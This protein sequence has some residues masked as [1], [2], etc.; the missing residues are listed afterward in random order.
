MEEVELQVVGMLLAGHHPILEVLRGQF[1]ECVVANREFTGCGF[2]TTFESQNCVP[3]IEIPKRIVIGDV[4]GDVE[5]LAFGCGFILF[6]DNGLI[7]T[8][9]CHLWGDAAFPAEPKFKRLYYVRSDSGLTETR[10][11]DWQA[12]FSKL[13]T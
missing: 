3:Q 4:C 7:G 11:R 1:S 6:V 9:E 10:E 2:F 5:G 13:S 8:L 12:L